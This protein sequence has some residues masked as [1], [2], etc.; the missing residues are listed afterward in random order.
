[1]KLKITLLSTLIIGILIVG[2]CEGYYHK[3]SGAQSEYVDVKIFGAVG[4]G[5][6]DDTEAFRKAAST[7]KPILVKNTGKAYLVS[8]RIRLYNSIKGEGN[9][10]IRMTDK[11]NRFVMPKKYAYGKYSIFHVGNYQ[12]SSQL[13]IEGLTLDGGWNGRYKGSE[14][15]AAIYIASSKNIIIRNNTIKNTLGDNILMYWYNSSFEKGTKNYCENITIENNV[16]DNPYRCNIAL[17]SGKNIRINNNKITKLND[18]VAAI[19]LEMDHWD[20]DGQVVQDVII[21]GNTITSVKTKYVISTLGMRDGVSNITMKQNKIIGSMSEGGVGINFDAAYGPI[22]Q[23]NI[24]G[25]QIDADL[26]VRLTGT[27]GNKEIVIAEN[28]SFT[29][30]NHGVVVNGSYV[31]NL[32][33]RNNQSV[34]SK[35]Y[36]SNI[37]LGKDVKRVSVHG[38]DFSSLNWS[39]LFFVQDIDQLD[40]YENNIKSKQAPIYFEPSGDN[41][42]KNIKIYKNKT[43][44]STIYKSTRKLQKLNSY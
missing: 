10:T 22:R 33:V 8:G 14:F 42:M 25:N 39:S 11:V 24:L 16:L 41:H 31:D 37:I 28:R 38:N 35:N 23:V 13:I 17:V 34:V 20:K 1:M 19:D 9:P 2:F 3:L 27:S 4:D 12:S 6:T 26:F 7:R 15:E 30:S 29:P 36:Y 18:F 40:I 43:N 5:K 21:F 44:S 32:I